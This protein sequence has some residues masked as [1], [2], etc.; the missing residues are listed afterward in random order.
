MMKATEPGTG[1]HRRRRRRLAFHL[2]IAIIPSADNTLTL[3]AIEADNLRT[4]PDLL[5][6]FVRFI[7]LLLH[8]HQAIALENAALRVQ[9]AAFHRKRR[10]PRLTTFD[11]L[12]W[13]GLSRVWPGW[14]GPLQYVQADRV[15]RWERERFRRFWA[16]LSRRNATPVGDR[17]PRS[18]FV[19]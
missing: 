3:K 2:C 1:D 6:C 5:L 11:R 7:R 17:R 10:R 16:R 14:R 18:R 15:V 13:V 12:F 8:G 9:I 4:M 19:G